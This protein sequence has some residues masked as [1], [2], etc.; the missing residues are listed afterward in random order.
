MRHSALYTILFSG[1]VCI[2]CAVL[3]SSAAVSLKDAQL[4]NAA[5]DKQRNVLLAAGLAQ[6]DERLDSEEVQRR[7]EAVRSLVIDLETGTATDIDPGTFDQAKAAKDPGTSRS[8]PANRAAVRRLPHHALV[9]EVLR[10]GRREMAVLPIEGYGLWS[11]LYGFLAVDADGQTIRGIAYYQHKETPGL[12]GEVDNPKWKALWPGRKIYGPSGE[13][14]IQVI[15][16]AAPPP[17]QAPHD[18][19]GLS[20]ATITSNGVSAMLRFW[21]GASGFRPYLQTFREGES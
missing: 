3:I 17:N 2:V 7:F 9:Y 20:G 14:A 4:H 16:G 18:V 5:L 6:A 21:L 15:K 8:A 11:T 19:D 12:G 10:E 13:P 1:A